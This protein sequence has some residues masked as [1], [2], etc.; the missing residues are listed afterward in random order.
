[1]GESTIHIII[2][3]YEDNTIN[4]NQF[5]NELEEEMMRYLSD[6]AIPLTFSPEVTARHIADA[7]T[8]SAPIPINNE[9]RTLNLSVHDPKTLLTIGL[10]KDEFQKVITQAV[11]NM[12]ESV[13]AIHHGN[14]IARLL[15]HCQ[16]KRDTTFSETYI[17]IP[18]DEN[19]LL[20][21]AHFSGTPDLPH[22]ERATIYSAENVSV[23]VFSQDVSE[24]LPDNLECITIQQ[25]KVK[26]ASQIFAISSQREQHPPA[27]PNA[28]TVRAQQRMQQTDYAG[29]W[30]DALVYHRNHPALLTIMTQHLGEALTPQVAMQIGHAGRH[31]EDLREALAAVQYTIAPSALAHPDGSEKAQ[32]LQALH[33]D[34]PVKGFMTGI[35]VGR[36]YDGQHIGNTQTYQSLDALLQPSPTANP[37]MTR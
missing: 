26:L 15:D 24:M 37:R 33:A 30:V 12:A 21:K 25:A 11:E 34:N 22:S 16:E 7:M 14:A 31:R 18:R 36:C 9:S 35:E 13:T 5:L 10:G 29:Q 27:F 32:T 17:V 2:D 20:R 19:G 6:T 1:M 3:D 4:H 8:A 23:P 28:E